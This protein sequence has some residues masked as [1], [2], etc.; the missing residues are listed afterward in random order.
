MPTLAW[1]E[2]TNDFVNLRIAQDTEGHF[3]AT[4]SCTLCFTDAELEDR[5]LRYRVRVFLVERESD[6]DMLHVDYRRPDGNDVYQTL[7]RADFELGDEAR[8]RLWELTDTEPDGH[9][10]IVSPGDRAD[11]KISIRKRIEWDK[12]PHEGSSLPLRA[13]VSVQPYYPAVSEYSPEG[14]FAAPLDD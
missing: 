5:P 3:E 2:E 11:E 8:D 12:L 7:S 13:W 1:Q 14:T 6:L 9:W 10:I 4:V